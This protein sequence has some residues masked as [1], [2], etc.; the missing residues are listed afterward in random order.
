MKKNILLLLYVLFALNGFS[1]VITPFAVQYQTSVKGGIR[2]LANSSIGCSVDP[3]NSGSSACTNGTD[4]VPPSG[5]WQDNSFNGTYIDIDGDPSTF[6]SSSDSLNL[7]TCSEILWAGLFWGGSTNG[8]AP[9]GYQNIKFKINNG[10]YVG[11]TASSSETNTIGFNTFHC[12]SDI[13]SLLTSQGGNFR[14]TVADIPS[15]RIGSSNQF[16]GWTIAVVF[17]NDLLT[18]R[19]L[20]VFKGLANVSGSSTV[21]IPV[22]GFLTPPTGPVSL[23]IGLMVHD[24]DRGLTGDGCSFSGMNQTPASTFVPLSDALNPTTNFFNS[25]ISNNGVLTP[26]RIP[27]MN[28]T[29]GL[30]AD[31]IV[32]NNISKNYIG[33]SATNFTF[34]QTTG[35]ETYLTQMVSTAIDIYE[36]DVRAGVRVIDLNGGS[37]IPGDTLEYY[38]SGINIGSDPALN[39]YFTDSIESNANYVLGSIE[40]IHGPNSGVKS[41][42]AGDDQAEY[43]S[44]SKTIRVRAGT[45][46]NSTSGGQMNN[47]PSGADSTVFKFRV[48]VTNE[49]VKFSCDNIIDNRA[50]IFGTGPTSGNIISAGSNPGIFDAFGCPV[51]G[52]TK[53]L[54]ISP[55][56]V[57]PNDTIIPGYCANKP[58]TDL[59]YSGYSY[60]NSSFSPVTT[61]VSTGTYYAINTA[62]AGCGDTIMITINGI[63]DCDFDDD[64]INDEVDLDDDNDG[65]LDT[66][67]CLGAG[68]DCDSDG[69]GIPNYQDLDSDNDGCSDAT[70]AGHGLANNS[71]IVPGPYGANGFADIAETAS[72]SGIANYTILD[73]GSGTSSFQDTLTNLCVPIANKDLVTIIEDTSNVYIDVQLNDSDLQGDSLITTI[74]S[75]PTSG[76]T[77]SI[78]NADSIL[79]TPPSNFNGI[80]TIIYQICDTTGVCDSDTLFVTVTPVNDAPSQGNETMSALE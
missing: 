31:I 35:G 45:G 55:P 57:F 64:G 29:G 37:A 18:M 23:E 50:V 5:S 10:S 74:I 28:N 58:L 44:V 69:D 51:S 7:P 62:S 70:E 46:A 19:Q 34:R 30:D 32:P 39:T 47:S 16:G 27:N 33:N 78:I 68:P 21:D 12:F 20:S 36:P 80:D 9:S 15:N 26:F 2:Y 67:E 56:C 3:N 22:S 72:E 66:D 1:Q 14:V 60:F 42:L 59:P 54:I 48:T 4:E 17:K 11:V 53:T 38:V 65:I 52:S 40:I 41:D 8:S 79:Y 76:G 43:N 13:T 25:T 24:G 63:L 73:N 49:C 77:V 6:Q 75:G 61:A 71:N